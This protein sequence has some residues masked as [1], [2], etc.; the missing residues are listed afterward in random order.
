MILHGITDLAFFTTFL[1]LICFFLFF[2]G[3]LFV[4]VELA[5]KFDRSFLFSG[6]LL[7]FLSLMM[8]LALWVDP[9][10]W[11]PIEILNISRFFNFVVCVAVIVLINYLMLITK[12]PNLKLQRMTTFLA[13]ICICGTY[14]KSVLLIQNNHIMAGYLYR[15]FFTSLSAY[16]LCVSLYL[17]LPALRSFKGESKQ[18]I[19]I[20]LVGILTIVPAGCIATI[21]TIPE[22]FINPIKPATIILFSGFSLFGFAMT[23]LFIQ[24]FILLIKDRQVAFE[25]LETAYTELDQANSLKEI[26]QSTAIINHEIKNF[27]FGISGNVQLILDYDK[28]ISE[29]TKKK[30]TA[31]IE[32][33]KRMSDFSMDILELS[34]AKILKEKVEISV[35]GVM[36][37]CIENHFAAKKRFFSF[38]GFEQD[39]LIHGDWNKLDHV[40]VNVFK[41]AFEAEATFIRI[42]AIKSPTVLLLTIEDDGIGCDEKAFKQIFTAFYTTKKNSRG[43]GLGMP[44]IKSI[45][46]SHGGYISAYSKN[47]MEGG[48]HGLVLNVSFPTYS[49]LNAQTDIP[50]Q[51]IVLIKEGIENIGPVIRVFQNVHFTPRIVQLLSDVDGREFSMGKM[52]VLANPENIVKLQKRNEKFRAYALM[53]GNDKQPTVMNVSREG[54]SE[55][56]SEEFVIANFVLADREAA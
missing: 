10:N 33:T 47:L 43:T 12:R 14:S 21:I 51:N 27:T 34:K 23:I 36:Q 32:T 16:C 35:Y 46:E 5:S 50:K 7:L 45:V 39:P 2:G 8:G 38:S 18:M 29:P 13:I 40:F 53:A 48:G 17:L 52:M 24:R 19:L 54:P 22:P 42:K 11:S 44:I 20:H 26:G 28:L 56:F 49:Q 6:L 4:T 15:A 25:K 9:K 31:I 1:H 55:A 41:N 3:L 30:L 37:R